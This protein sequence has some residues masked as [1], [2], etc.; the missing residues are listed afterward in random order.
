MTDKHKARCW[1]GKLLGHKW[2]CFAQEIVW[3]ERERRYVAW[4]PGFHTDAPV[5]HRRPLTHD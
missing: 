4:P 3:S 1:C 2:D 5:S